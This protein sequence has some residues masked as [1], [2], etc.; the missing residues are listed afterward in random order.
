MHQSR[1]GNYCYNIVMVLIDCPECAGELSEKASACP[2]CGC[3]SS[4]FR[5]VEPLESSSLEAEKHLEEASEHLVPFWIPLD[6]RNPIFAV[7][8]LAISFC[9]VT[10]FAFGTNENW[11][12]GY[13]LLIQV[14]DPI[15]LLIIAFGAFLIQR[16]FFT[17]TTK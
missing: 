1:L 13:A 14:I 10:L 16:L 7:P 4:D 11:T 15:R 3:P 17:N 12:L 5:K 6:K 9:C 8:S 2:H